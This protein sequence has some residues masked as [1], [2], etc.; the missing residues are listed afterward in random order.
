MC[1]VY[2]TSIYSV[3]G[4]SLIISLFGLADPGFLR[5]TTATIDSLRV[6]LRGAEDDPSHLIQALL[7]I[8][9]VSYSSQHI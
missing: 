3:P 5:L 7:L 8:T 1:K 4:V 2:C 9:L 6:R